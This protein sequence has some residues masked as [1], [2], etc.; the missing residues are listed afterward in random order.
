MRIS[1]VI[2]TRNQAAYLGACIDSCLQ[3]GIEDSEILV[4]DGASTDETA[5]VVQRFGERVRFVSEPDDG[6]ASA[7]NKGVRMARGE[8][9]AWI[10]SDDYYSD[11]GAINALLSVM[12]D[13]ADIAYGDGLRV[14]AHGGALGRYAAHPVEKTA[15]IVMW[16]AS[17]VLQPALLFRRELFLRVGGLDE[18]LHYALDY[19]LWLRMFPAASSTRQ[20]HRTIACARYH[21]DAKSVA[22]MRRQILEAY[23]VKRRAIAALSMPLSQQLRTHLGVATM[24]AYWLAV[25]SGLRR[26]V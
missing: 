8:V 14:D 2:P 22:H 25:R 16:P 18:S 10:N 21:A 7:V 23:Q 20:V 4:I 26:L 3:Q 15:D 6:Q 9:I 19:D 13:G 1:F 5:A 12:E 17:F 24:W 11:P